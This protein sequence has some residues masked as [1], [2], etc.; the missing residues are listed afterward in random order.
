MFH[1]STYRPSSLKDFSHLSANFRMSDAK[2]CCPCHWRTT[3]CTSVHDTNF[4]PPSVF[5]P[6]V[7]CSLRKTL[8]TIYCMHFRMNLT[9]IYI[10]AHKNT[11]TA[12]LSLQ[13]NFR[14][15]IAIFN[16]YKWRHSDVIITKL[17]GATQ[18]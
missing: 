16:V 8:V 15:N 18:N 10:F 17:T 11:I 13:E 2:N 14:V 5:T 6:N 7:N 3:D 1:F 4:Y 12:C 9:C